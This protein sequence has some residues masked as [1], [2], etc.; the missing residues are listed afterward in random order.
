VVVDGPGITAGA[1]GRRGRLD[2]TGRL[3]LR[4]DRR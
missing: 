2:G 1:T 4:E 3:W